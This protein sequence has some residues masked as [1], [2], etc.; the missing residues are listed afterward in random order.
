MAFGGGGLPVRVFNSIRE[1]SAK[2]VAILGTIG[3][4]ALFYFLIEPVFGIG[5]ACGG[6]ICLAIHW[7]ARLDE[8]PFWQ[9]VFGRSA[10]YRESKRSPDD[11]PVNGLG[12]Q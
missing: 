3:V 1:P 4:G 7:G 9:H 11:E 2:I 8:R 6:V 10:V 5:V 12:S